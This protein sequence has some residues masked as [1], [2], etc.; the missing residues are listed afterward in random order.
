MPHTK[1]EEHVRKDKYTQPGRQ[2]DGQT[3]SHID[4]GVARK[5]TGQRAEMGC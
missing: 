2:T 1:K 5:Y 4:Y 3:D